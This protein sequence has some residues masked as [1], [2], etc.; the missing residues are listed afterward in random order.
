LTTLLILFVFAVYIF[1][2]YFTIRDNFSREAFQASLPKHTALLAPVISEAAVDVVENVQPVYTQAVVDKAE[3]FLPEFS[4]A[5]AEQTDVLLDDLTAF[6]QKELETRLHRIVEA[7]AAEFRGQYPDLTDQ[8]LQ[9]FIEDTENRLGL[10]FAELSQEIVDQSLPE[11]M[12]MKLLSE[13]MAGDQPEL[14]EDR[15]FQLFIHKLLMLL[16]QEIMEG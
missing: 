11:V 12:E 8:Q 10:L 6:G 13:S 9:T 15:L 5:A 14:D 2:F 16:D 1:L 4:L 7:Y 3:T